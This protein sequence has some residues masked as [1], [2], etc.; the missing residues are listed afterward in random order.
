MVVLRVA[1]GGAEES[2]SGGSINKVLT[3]HHGCFSPSNAIPNTSKIDSSHGKRNG[4]VTRMSP[5]SV[6]NIFVNLMD[7]DFPE[8]RDETVAK[9]SVLFDRK[10]K[11]RIHQNRRKIR[12]KS[13]QRKPKTFRGCCCAKRYR[14]VYP[15]VFGTLAAKE[16][17]PSHRMK[18]K[19]AAQERQTTTTAAA[20]AKPR[21]HAQLLSAGIWG[22]RG[23]Q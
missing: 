5:K 7:T 8:I 13:F 17:T 23:Q 1:G 3:Y 21:S 20:A 4:T 9:E 10:K 15:R 18:M 19:Q 22:D 12:E 14:G 6:K 11:M 16:L 2:F